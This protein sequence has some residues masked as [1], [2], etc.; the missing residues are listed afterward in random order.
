MKSNT[1][2]FCSRDSYILR[3]YVH[4]L[5]IQHWN[6]PAVHFETMPIV[7]GIYPK[8]FNMLHI[9]NGFQLLY[10]LRRIFRR[11]EYMF[12]AT[13]IFPSQYKWISFML[14]KKPR[15]YGPI[16]RQSMEKAWHILKVMTVITSSWSRDHNM[17]SGQPA[18]IFDKWSILQSHDCNLW[19]SSWLQSQL[20]KP[21]LFNN[22]PIC[23]TTM[24]FA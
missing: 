15:G 22:Q 5:Q 12:L 18:H 4:N 19:P 16:Y 9:M 20:Q 23:W 17:G 14:Y 3:H 13:M 7:W 1:H 6:V 24:W 11:V 8:D 10:M 21:K 2:F